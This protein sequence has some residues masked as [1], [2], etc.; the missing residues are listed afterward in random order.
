GTSEGNAPWSYR[1]TL[2]S[3][4]DGTSVTLMVTENTLAGASTG[5]PY[6][7]L[8]GTDSAPTNWGCAHPN[9]VA[10]MGSDNVCSG[11]DGTGTCSAAALATGP[12]SLAPV[13]VGATV[14]TGPGCKLASKR[15]TTENMNAGN[16]AGAPGGGM[17]SA[18]SL[19][20]GAIVVVM[21]D[22]SGRTIRDN[23]DGV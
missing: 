4:T 18:N 12:T 23:I 11:P 16:R 19:H 9:F 22:G 10:F 21:C 20:P 5:S 7:S 13:Q 17:P 2:S 1:T 15:W 3:I 14:V 6:T 8:G